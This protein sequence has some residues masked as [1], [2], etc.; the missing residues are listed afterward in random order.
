MHLRFSE[1]ELVTLAEMVTL[2]TEM[3]NYNQQEGS[4]RDFSRFEA[5][6]EKI[7]S[8]ARRNGVDLPLETDPG[9]GK[10]RIADSENSSYLQTC[11]EEIR[12]SLF[13]EELMIRLSERDLI[14]EV[15][16]KKWSSLSEDAQEKATKP[17]ERRYWRK[18][19]TEG[20]ESLHWISP[21]SHS[22]SEF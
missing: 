10:P 8:A 21:N 15:G 13:W 20:I 16:A 22:N 17:R 1:D 9:S 19:T 18:F 5:M 11:L 2:A 7:L 3:A 12:N 14:R 6:E 4:Q